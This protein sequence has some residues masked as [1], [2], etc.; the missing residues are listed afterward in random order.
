[1]YDQRAINFL[2]LA[3]QPDL[4]SYIGKKKISL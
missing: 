2:P 1:M 3:N 4:N